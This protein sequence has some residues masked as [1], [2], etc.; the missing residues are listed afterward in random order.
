MHRLNYTL[1]VSA[2]GQSGLGGQIKSDGRSDHPGIIP[3]YGGKTKC[4]VFGG[5]LVL[6]VSF[7]VW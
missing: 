6:V 3:F 4:L 5:V 1:R 2:D 7:S